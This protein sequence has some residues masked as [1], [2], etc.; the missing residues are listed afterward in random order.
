MPRLHVTEDAPVPVGHF[1]HAAQVGNLLYVSGQGPQD[2]R[3]GNVPEGTSAQT[4]ATIQNLSAILNAC[5]SSLQRVVKVNVYLRHTEDFQAFNDAY[6][7]A[8][9]EH[10]PART[11][12]CPDLLGT[13]LVEIDCVAEV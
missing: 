1:A 4:T 10:R 13:I 2:P 7:E 8:F 5:G 9:G 11:T 3:T 6:A 12:T